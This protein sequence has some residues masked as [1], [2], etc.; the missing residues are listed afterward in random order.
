M[1][2]EKAGGGSSYGWKVAEI[3]R[4]YSTKLNILQSKKG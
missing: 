2:E 3:E 1:K 4:I